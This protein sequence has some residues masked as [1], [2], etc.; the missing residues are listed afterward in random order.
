MSPLL[1]VL[2]IVLFIVIIRK[3]KH[4]KERMGRLEQIVAHLDSELDKKVSREAPRPVQPEAQPPVGDPTLSAPMAEAPEPTAPPIQSAVLD[5]FLPSEADIPTEPPADFRLADIE[6]P[7]KIPESQPSVESDPI[8]PLPKKPSV[9]YTKWQTFKASVDWEQ[10]TGVKLFAWLGGLALFIAAGFFVKFSIDRNLIPPALRLAISA[11]IG[12]SLIIWAGRFSERAYRV[13]RHTLASGGIGVLYS[14]VFAATLYYEYLTKPLGFGLLTVVSAAAFVLAVFY[15]SKAVSILG[16]VGAYATPVLVS[17]GQG[18]LLMLWGYL[19]VI[20][21]GH[22][23][24]VRRLA[25]Q[26][27]L[28][29]AAVGT[30]ATLALGTWQMFGAT[31]GVI[32]AS[33]W[34]LNLVLFAFFLGFPNDD[35]RDHFATRWTGIV[36]FMM[37]LAVAVVLLDQPGWS[38]LLVVTVAQATAV[39][40]AWRNRGWYGHVIP[41]GALSF[42]VTLG[43]VLFDFDATQISVGFLLLLLYGAFGGLGTVLLVWRYGL[44]RSS[45]YWLRIFPLAIV[46]VGLVVVFE[47]PL[48]SFWIWPLLLGLVSIGIAISVALRAFFQVS[49][50]V[51]FFLLGALNWLFQVPG[52]MLGMGFFAFIMGAGIF[53]CVGLF[54]L[55]KRLPQLIS[56]LQPDTPN[57]Q[58]LQHPVET[59]PAMAQWLSAAPAAAVCVLLAASFLIAYPHYPHPGMVTLVCFLAMVLFAVHRLGFEIPGVAAL[60][61]VAAAQGVFVFHPFLGPQVFFSAQTWSGALFLSALAL[62]FLFFRSFERWRNLW[63]GW[64][65][66]EAAQAVFI[67][68][69]TQRLWPEFQAQWVPLGLAVFKLPLVAVLLRRLAGSPQRHVILAFHGGVLLFYLSTLPVLVLDQG[70]IGLTFVL[71]AFALL[72][73]NRRIQHPGLRWVALAMAPAGLVILFVNLPQLKTLQSMP[74]L[75][76]ATLSV[77]AAVAVLLA[78]VRPAEYPQRQLRNLDVPNYFLWLTVGT[79]FVLVNLIVADLFAPLGTRFGVY[80]GQDFGH[81]AGYA[82]AWVAL[83]GLLRRLTHLP[84]SM[85]WV[86]L[87]LVIAGVGGMILLPVLLPQAVVSMRPFINVGVALYLPLLVGLYFL[88]HKEPREPGE[89]G[90]SWDSAPGLL[91]NLLLALFLGAAFIFLKLQKG[92]VFAPGYPFTLLISQT[93]SKAV[94]SAAGWMVYGL[95]LLLWPKRLDRPFRL[96]G[97]VLIG[98]ALVKTVLVPFQ[99]RVAFAQMTPLINPPSALFLF[100]L[101]ALIYLT[102]RTWDSRWPLGRVVPRNLWG[103]VLALAA[104]AFLN[105]EIA[106]VFAIQGRSF[107]MMTH[108]SLAMQLAYSIGWLLFAIGLL[109]VGIRWQVVKVRWAAII[110]IVLTACKIFI[111][112][113]SSLGQLYRV[114]SLLGLAVVLILVSFLYQRFLTTEGKKNA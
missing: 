9:W 19:A 62:P 36:T 25:S 44:N 97:F 65:L 20:N 31:P 56:L 50:L 78:A 99:F 103:I 24:V 2:W 89:P 22:Y 27:L 3:E 42:L 14:V 110:A 105:I 43:W 53:L 61:G 39:G 18:N 94:A 32:I 35:P 4:L 52:G 77:A 72:W 79:G 13:M 100:C 102:R 40:L 101:V 112:D 17:T 23:Q 1:I 57:T 73:L 84:A 49:L 91:K 46:L 7:V 71:E 21:I 93:L 45:L 96:A 82:L 106:S 29:V 113:V 58:G 34:I 28:L 75:N 63:G 48:A 47:Q 85:R 83:G 51:L 74:I 64:A 111:L 69:V 98:L 88:F 59:M 60:L 54:V 6:G 86:G 5:E 67:L 104:F 8:E 33:A 30:A 92:I 11:L 12:I 107:S 90:E 81:W 87:W 109:V 41:Y 55:I 10:F 37:T 114:A 70:W 95:G 68:Y 15:R 16:A 108:G 38:S 76:S 80:P 66:F 26:G